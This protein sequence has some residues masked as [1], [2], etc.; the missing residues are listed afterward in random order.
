MC[1]ADRRLWCE[2]RVAL[3]KSLAGHEGVTPAGGGQQWE[4]GAGECERS[5]E[6][7]LAASIRLASAL[8]A[9]TEVP[10]DLKAMIAQAQVS[11]FIGAM[12]C[13][14][15]MLRRGERREEWGNPPLE[16]EMGWYSGA[17]TQNL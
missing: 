2:C 17:D 16:C 12:E 13:I 3:A 6:W 14:T 11:W 10:P 8:S 7:E 9:L 5:G 1:C 4:E 15:C